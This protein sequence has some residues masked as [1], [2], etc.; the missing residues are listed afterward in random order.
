MRSL[1]DA[2]YSVVSL[3]EHYNSNLSPIIG[4]LASTRSQQHLED[5]VPSVNRNRAILTDYRA[6][7]VA[8][9]QGC[10]DKVLPV[11][12]QSKRIF[13]WGAGIHTSQL[14][15]NTHLLNKCHVSGLTDTS[16]LKW[17]L[18]QGDWICQDPASIDWQQGDS[19]LISSYASEKEIYDALNWLR[20]LGVATLRLHN[21]DDTRA[22]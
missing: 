5:F 16:S 19:V 14:V 13:L 18:R 8:Y 10:L 12:Q 17:G 7:E 3:I 2:G 11:L 21:I 6:K 20:D 22:H 15:A 9:W 4:V 1:T